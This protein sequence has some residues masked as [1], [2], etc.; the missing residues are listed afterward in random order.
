MGLLCWAVLGAG[1]LQQHKECSLV[2]SFPSIHIIANNSETK[3]FT[4]VRRPY[5]SPRREWS[6]VSANKKSSPQ[7]TYNTHPHIVEL[8]AL[9]SDPSTRALFRLVCRS[10]R[11]Y[12]DVRSVLPGGVLFE[13]H[14]NGTPCNLETTEKLPVFSPTTFEWDGKD[15]QID[16]ISRAPRVTIGGGTTI[17]YIEELLSYLPEHSPVTITHDGTG[18]PLNM[19]MLAPLYLDVDAVVRCQCSRHQPGAVFRHAATHLTVH[20]TLPALL[21]NQAD[22]ACSLLRGLWSPTIQLLQL[23]FESPDWPFEALIPSIFP[24]PIV[25]SNLHIQFHFAWWP[26]YNVVETADNLRILLASYFGISLDRVTE[27][28][29]VRPFPTMPKVTCAHLPE[30]PYSR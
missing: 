29:A 26:G 10:L 8:I 1:H 17:P 12:V 3:V 14:G 30:R 25:N 2:A 23:C 15:A 16:V 20:F 21:G 5:V 27:V 6:K 13:W 4:M 11:D 22:S 24:H 7:V 18:P 28:I 9:F 19:D